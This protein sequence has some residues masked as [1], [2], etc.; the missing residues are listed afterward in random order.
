MLDNGTLYPEAAC[1]CNG[2]CVPAGVSNLT[3]CRYGAPAF[4]SFPHFYLADSFFTDNVRG[5]RPDK[6]K[7]QFYLTLEPVCTPFILSWR[8]ICIGNIQYKNK[9]NDNDN[10]VINFHTIIKKFSYV[11]TFYIYVWKNT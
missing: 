9:H 6:E 4:A 3:V 10:A 2:G 1:F 8:Q 5:M 11:N 7:H